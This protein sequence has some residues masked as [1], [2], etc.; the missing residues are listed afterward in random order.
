MEGPV[1]MY[2]APLKAGLVLAL[3]ATFAPDFSIEEFQDLH[4]SIEYPIKKSEYPSI[5]VTFDEALLQTAGIDHREV[6]EDGTVVLR[7]RFEGHASFTVAALSSYER[8]RLYDELVRVVAFARSS[9]QTN[10]F[11]LYVEQN[12]LIA[13]T[14]DFDQIEPQ[15]EG[16]MPGTPWGSDEVM[17]EKTMAIQV[18]GEFT[19]NVD[20]GELVPL[21]KI[22]IEGRLAPSTEESPLGPIN[23]DVDST[24][25]GPDGSE[26]TPALGDW[27]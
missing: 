27:H 2:Y 12:D 11:R 7:W 22:T 14:I 5:W 15:G 24:R 3:R 9:E 19:T 23:W 17:Y 1:L 20:T 16:A 6:N 26:Q 10:V 8:D 18:I 13:M 21:E 25:V 4:V